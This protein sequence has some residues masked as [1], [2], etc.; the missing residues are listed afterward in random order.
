MGRP[1]LLNNLPKALLLF[2]GEKSNSTVILATVR[3]GPS[4]IHCY[5]PVQNSQA[6][7]Q[8]HQRTGMVERGSGPIPF[9]GC[10]CKS[11]LDI[12]RC[13][14]VRLLPI[15]PFLQFGK[16]RDVGLCVI[17]FAACIAPQRLSET[18]SRSL[19]KT[20]FLVTQSSRFRSPRTA[21]GV[22]SLRF[23]SRSSRLL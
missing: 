5:L 15:K 18:G 20:R 7:A 8:R 10:L 11:V 4:R 17:R 13:Q 14:L 22:C 3:N 19:G 21:S 1:L 12:F 23:S 6:I 2:F 16:A 9:L